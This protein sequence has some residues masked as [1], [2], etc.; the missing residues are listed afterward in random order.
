MVTAV[1]LVVAV[2]VV[3]VVVV[4]VFV[5]RLT[6]FFPFLTLSLQFC[7]VFEQRLGL[8][9]YLLLLLFKLW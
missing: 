2:V 9:L 6:L 1:I 8:L 5:H 7:K 4:V 3:V